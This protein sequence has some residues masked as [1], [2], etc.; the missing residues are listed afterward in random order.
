MNKLIVS[1]LA[2][3]LITVS[4]FAQED[5]KTLGKVIDDLSYKWDD[6]AKVLN[7]YDGLSKFC[8][9]EEYRL[10]IIQL[11][12]DVHHYDSVLYQRLVKASRFG[13]E[14]HEVK[15]TIEEIEKF[16]E[17]YDMKSFIHFLHTECSARNEIEH[18][19]DDLKSE[20]NIYSYDGQIYVLE[21]ELNKF[22]SHITKRVDHIR[23]HVHHLHIE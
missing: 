15:K 1:F 16:E 2:F 10:N 18:N 13:N 21:N 12:Q 20:I 4:T 19:A 7:N 8:A 3:S 14:S 5:H 17:G 23:E 9:N 11:L 6:E 22:V